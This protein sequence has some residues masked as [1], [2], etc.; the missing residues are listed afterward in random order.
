MNTLTLSR[1]LYILFCTATTGSIKYIPRVL[2]NHKEQYDGVSTTRQNDI[3]Y[4]QLC[5]S[6][7]SLEHVS[8]VVTIAIASSN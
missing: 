7:L 8:T 1:N 5:L 3:V 4:Y 2:A 6:H